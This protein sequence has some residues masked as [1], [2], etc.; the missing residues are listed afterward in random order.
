MPGIRRREFV[1][2]LGGAAA[3]WPV[4]ARAQQPERIRRIGMFAGLS[5]TDPEL[6]ARKGAFLQALQQLGWT[7]GRNAHID[8]RLDGGD[9]SK[10]A[11][12][13]VALAPDV[14]VATGS[15]SVSALQKTTRTVPIV[16][17]VS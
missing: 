2:L 11:A 15:P 16:S 10:D 4:A 12:E 17:S 7:D 9:T 14:I 1:S 13:L 3:A 6:Q 8:Y 5:E